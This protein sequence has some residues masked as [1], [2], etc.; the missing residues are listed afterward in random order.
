MLLFKCKC[1]KACCVQDAEA[2]QKAICGHCGE[3]IQV[4]LDSDVDC[5]LLFRR[6]DPDAGQALTSTDFQ[7]LLNRG[8]LYSYDLVW[9]DGEWLPL[10]KVYELS[11]PPAIE[12]DSSIAEI[13]LDFQ[14]LPP[15]EG[16]AKVPKKK[17]RMVKFDLPV[18]T[19][20]GEQEARRPVN[21]KKRILNGIKTF[22]ILTV[23]FFGG[24]RL[25]RIVNFILKRVS[26]VMVINTFDVPC[27]FKISGYDWQDLPKNTH[28]TQSDVYVAFSCRK[29]IVFAE[30]NL[31]PL[32]GMPRSEAEPFIGTALDPP[33]MRVP[34]KPGYDTVVNPGGRAA[35]GVYDFSILDGL[36]LSSAELKSLST[37]LE[38]AKPPVSVLKVIQQIQNLVKDTYKESRKDLFFSS[39]DFNLDA[40]GII[41]NQD[42]ST[43]KGKA[44]ADAE[45]NKKPPLSLVYPVARTMNFRNGSILFDPETLE[46]ERSITLVSREFLPK[47]GYSVTG[48]APRLQIRYE[49]N[50]LVLQLSNLTG[51]VKGPQNAVYNAQWNYLARMNKAGQWTWLWTAKYQQPGTGKKAPEERILTIDQNGAETYPKGK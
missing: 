10:G 27:K 39:K 37:E 20:A 13:T 30:S 7:H 23:L 50:F 2:G 32:T 1:G 26:N 48:A 18:M 45:T 11:P 46:T 38:Q 14:D 5:I 16:H 43:P 44:D 4:P 21:L 6:G 8:E 24:I 28:M 35:F 34:I 22:I 15:V 31:D 12:M 41:R 29:K 19:T 42:F 40:L 49:K 25:G 36:S 33:S 9:K 47:Q 17:K 3:E 51:T